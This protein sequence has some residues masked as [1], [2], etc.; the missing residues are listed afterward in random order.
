MQPMPIYPNFQPTSVVS[1]EPP[2]PETK[3]HLMSVEQIC[4]WIRKLGNFREWQGADI[5]AYTELFRQEEIDGC[6]LVKLSIKDFGKLGMK[7]LGH[8]I[9]IRREVEEF[10]GQSENESTGVKYDDMTKARPSYVIEAPREK[11]KTLTVL[12]DSESENSTARSN[13]RET[14]GD[15]SPSGNSGSRIRR[16]QC[17]SGAKLLVHCNLRTKLYNDFR[18]FG[19][20]VEVEPVDMK[21]NEYVIQFPDIKSA[22]Q[23]FENRQQLGYNLEKHKEDKNRT[24]LN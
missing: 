18:K 12:T 17:P 7:K 13:F 22:E 10:D 8:K 5:R 4:D 21:P 16:T 9:I 20:E 15:S 11:P 6:Q 24:P 3:I 2:R 23:A 19:Y 14:S 1:R